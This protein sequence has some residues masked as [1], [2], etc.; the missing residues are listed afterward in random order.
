MPGHPLP[1]ASSHKILLEI[2]GTQM[3]EV[4]RHEGRQGDFV[5]SD[6]HVRLAHRFLWYC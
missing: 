4:F 3:A 5:G 6:V 1:V 2:L